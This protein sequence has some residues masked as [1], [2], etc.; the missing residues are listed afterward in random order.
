MRTRWLAA[1]LD[2]EL[3]DSSEGNGSQ[4]KD[5]LVRIG[6]R[7]S[8]SCG[9]SINVAHWSNWWLIQPEAPP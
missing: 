6:R 9:M 5:A 4:S 1:G 2:G 3:A 7:R 8:E